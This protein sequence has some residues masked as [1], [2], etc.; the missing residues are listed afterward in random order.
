M[1]VCLEVG[2][3]GLGQCARIQAMKN[4]SEE[5]VVALYVGHPE[6]QKGHYPS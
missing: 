2:W 3:L 4:R 5:C 6:V 1:A